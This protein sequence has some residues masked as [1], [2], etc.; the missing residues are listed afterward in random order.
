MAVT[1]V[2]VTQVNRLARLAMVGSV[3]VTALA[4]HVVGVVA[5]T[6]SGG[7]PFETDAMAGA[8]DQLSSGEARD[9]LNDRL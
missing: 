6:V 2:A 3:L 4:H 8:F 7:N 5:E 1:T 9:Y